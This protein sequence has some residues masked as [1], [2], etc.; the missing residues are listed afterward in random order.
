MGAFPL[1]E[2]RGSLGLRVGKLF[3][4]GKEGSSALVCQGMVEGFFV[5][6]VWDGGGVDAGQSQFFQVM[7]VLMDAGK[8]VKDSV[9]F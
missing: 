8:T 3:P 4:V 7:Q 1:W 9:F 5:E 6:G 2:K